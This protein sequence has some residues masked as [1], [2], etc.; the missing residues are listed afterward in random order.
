MLHNFTHVLHLSGS[1]APYFPL[2][3]RVKVEFQ[4][5]SGAKYTLAVEGKLS[6]DKVLKIID[7]MEIMDGNTSLE[8]PEIDNSTTFG[9]ISSIIEKSYAGKEFSTADIARDYE[10]QHGQ[11]VGLSTVSTYLSRMT[12]RGYLKRQK[13]GNS[14][15]FRRTYLTNQAPLR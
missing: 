5:D 14:W 1:Q 10:E 13:F 8:Q 12:Q 6:R 11:P 4:D 7:L 3:K 9:R 15:V 2:N